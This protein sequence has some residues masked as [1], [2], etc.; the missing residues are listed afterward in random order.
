MKLVTQHIFDAFYQTLNISEH[1]SEEFHGMW[2]SI[3]L[4][5]W[6]S[7]AKEKSLFDATCILTTNVKKHFCDFLIKKIYDCCYGSGS[8]YEIYEQRRQEEIEIF[9]SKLHLSEN[10]TIYFK[11][12][13]EYIGDFCSFSSKCEQCEEEVSPK[14]IAMSLQV[15]GKELCT[16]CLNSL[17]N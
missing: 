11:E 12:K 4:D 5:E 1:E 2:V 3:T 7:Y 15:D 6:L 17:Y 8:Y 9:L 14:I 16:S 10:A 13:V